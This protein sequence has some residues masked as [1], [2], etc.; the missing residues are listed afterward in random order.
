MR[1]PHIAQEEEEGGEPIAD[2]RS[3]QEREAQ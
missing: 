1:M 3:N 2:A